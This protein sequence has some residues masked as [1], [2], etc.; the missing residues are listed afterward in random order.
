M[1]FLMVWWVGLIEILISSCPIF[2]SYLNYSY[3]FKFTELFIINA[4]NECKVKIIVYFSF[5][6]KIVNEYFSEIT[7]Y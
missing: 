2:M 5:L 3:T 1:G 4:S 7:L 6:N